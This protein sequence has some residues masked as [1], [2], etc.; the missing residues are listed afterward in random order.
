MGR[1]G[2]RFPRDFN[3]SLDQARG[4]VLDWARDRS[5]DWAWGR[6]CG[7]VRAVRVRRELID[8]LLRLADPVVVQRQYRIV[9]VDEQLVSEEPCHGF[10]DLREIVEG[11]LLLNPALRQIADAPRG[12]GMVQEVR[13]YFA[14]AWRN[15]G[16]IVW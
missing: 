9:R 5:L 16:S 15:V 7:C 13:E 2:D 3:R 4:R 11:D 6:C 14:D 12:T 8:E 10:A 1:G